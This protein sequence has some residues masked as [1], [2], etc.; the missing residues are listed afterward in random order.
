MSAGALAI[1][2]P[3]TLTDRRNEITTVEVRGTVAEFAQREVME[4][5]PVIFEFAVESGPETRRILFSIS[6]SLKQAW[7]KPSVVRASRLLALQENWDRQGAPQ[8]KPTTLQN[9]INAI[10]SF[11][12]S[13][14]AL[15]QWTPTRDGGVQLDWHER[16]ID[17]EIAFPPEGRGSEVVFVDHRKEL[18][19]FDGSVDERTDQLRRVFRERL[20]NQ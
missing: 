13:A 20:I 8:I 12:E 19:D 15:P 18:P 5:K 1:L 17:L 6:S 9:A 3:R 10:S 11:M 2:A 14:S 4:A 16:G 7:L